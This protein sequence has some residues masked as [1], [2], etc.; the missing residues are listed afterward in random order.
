[1]IKQNAATLLRQRGK[2]PYSVTLMIINTKK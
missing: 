2:Y 1:M